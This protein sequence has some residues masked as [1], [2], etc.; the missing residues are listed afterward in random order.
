MSEPR[1]YVPGVEE[2]AERQLPADEA[3]HLTR[4][5]RLGP[6]DAVR[7]FDGAGAEFDAEITGVTRSAV[8]VRVGNPAESAVEPPVRLTVAP[9]LIKGEG[10]DEIVRDAVMM[11]AAA[12]RPVITERTVVKSR[13]VHH[14]RR[15]RS[16]QER[17]QRVALAAVKQSG[18]AVLPVVDA[19]ATLDQVLATDASAARLVFVE[20]SAD[21]LVSDALAL[22]APASAL[23]VIGPE[24]GWSPAELQLFREKAMTFVRIGGR[25]ITSERATIAALAVLTAV[26]ERD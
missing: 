22:A 16:V 13:T 15:P 21:I 14:E 20:P 8:H 17:W 2:G 12:V 6:G 11:G 3:A 24:G 18:R 4:V 9:A 10:F 23:V 7:V 25:T 1:V 26:W 19:P 5:L